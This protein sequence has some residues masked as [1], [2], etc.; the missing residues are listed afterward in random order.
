LPPAALL[1][2]KF[3]L[4][5]VTLPDIAKMAPPAPSPP[6]PPEPPAPPVALPLAMVRLLMSTALPEPAAMKKTRKLLLPSI[7]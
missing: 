1:P 6:P 3:T 4:V 7:T 5:S 2:A